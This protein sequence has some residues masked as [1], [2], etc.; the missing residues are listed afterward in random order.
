MGKRSSE[1]EISVVS[2][3]GKEKRT[4]EVICEK[5][6]VVRIEGEIHKFY[7]IP[8]DLEEMILGNLKSRGINPSLSN[9]KKLP[10]MN[11]MLTFGLV[12]G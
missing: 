12:K 2:R 9:I 5:E 6:V 10:L 8:T 3:D 11:L 7:C 4:D 1:I